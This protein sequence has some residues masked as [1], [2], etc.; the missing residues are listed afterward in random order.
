MTDKPYN[1]M[2]NAGVGMINETISLL[3]L[4]Q[5][6][7]SLS[8][9]NKVALESGRFP[10]ITARRLR[11]LLA[12][13]I[14]PRY[15]K[16][17]GASAILL[18]SVQEHFSTNEVKQLLF[19]YTC[20]DSQILTDFARQVYWGAYIS[21]KETLST[22]EAFDFVVRANQDGK[23]FKPWS[24]STL[25]RVARYL[26]GSCADF[27]LLE[28]GAKTN[29]KI[30]PFQIEPKVMAILAYDLHFKGYGDNRVVNDQEWTLFG[31]EK[32]DVTNEFKRLS[33]RG[34]WIVQ[35]AADVVRIGWKY[36]AMQELIDVLI[37]E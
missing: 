32:D 5:P 26:T 25:K 1:T 33:Y 30:L 27:G 3:N 19:I 12:E 10:K 8:E 36:Q 2:L 23:T 17:N 35:T 20:R 4:W 21:G 37:K 31:L 15:L 9:L 14:S 24:E 6:G 29:R 18:K 22:E 34:W 7:M 13:C 11:N 28:T 16:N